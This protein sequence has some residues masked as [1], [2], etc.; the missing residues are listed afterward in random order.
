[1]P[2][3]TGISSGITVVLAVTVSAPPLPGMPR[4]RSRVKDPPA[5]R[6]PKMGREACNLL[7]F[8]L[9]RPQSAAGDAE[10]IQDGDTVDCRGA[11]TAT[12][13]PVQ[14]ATARAAPSLVLFCGLEAEVEEVV[15]LRTG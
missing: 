3:S 9:H 4:L 15:H 2:I 10:H 8:R 14:D 1:M 11:V 12:G 6:L 7:L 5:P 13:S